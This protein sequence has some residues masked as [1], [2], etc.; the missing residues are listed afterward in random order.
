MLGEATAEQELGDLPEI[1][2]H[3]AS[4]RQ[5]CAGPLAQALIRIPDDRCL[6]DER[7]LEGRGEVIGSFRGRDIYA[8]VRYLGMTYRFDRTLPRW[9]GVR[10]REL[11][12]EPGLVYVTD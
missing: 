10:E 12:L 6:D 7:V 1:E 9:R 11:L 5:H 8:W 2:G 3:V 4:K